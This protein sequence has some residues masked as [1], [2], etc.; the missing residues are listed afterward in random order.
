MAKSELS[1][2]EH[3]FHLRVEQSQLCAPS[4]RKMS[5]PSVESAASRVG[6][7]LIPINHSS[8]SAGSHVVPGSN[9]VFNSPAPNSWTAN[10]SN[11]NQGS[12]NS[13]LTSLILPSQVAL[14]QGSNIQEQAKFNTT[15]NPP[16]WSLM[17]VPGTSSL[18]A[19]ILFPSTQSN[20][21]QIPVK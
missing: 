3:R 10:Y 9:L 20:V 5:D 11:P 8:F 17:S 14:I 2:L 12:N 13:S 19:N 7:G 16:Q 1:K 4:V 6:I 18:T 15:S 21:L